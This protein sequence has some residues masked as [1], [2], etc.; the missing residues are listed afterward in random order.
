M[1]ESLGKLK[2]I[3]AYLDINID[4]NRFASRKQIQKIVYLIQEFGIDLNF[5]FSWYLHGPYCKELTAA[6]Y[7]EELD[8]SKVTS[9]SMSEKERLKEM[10]KFLNSDIKSSQKLELIA[11]LHY[12][13]DIG[14]KQNASDDEIIGL[15]R[16]RKPF[17][18]IDLINYYYK[19]VKEKFFKT[20]SNGVK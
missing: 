15:L 9:L 16:E 13:M 2:S 17:F 4:I 5:K 3:I 18:D 20:T 14:L 8:K 11:S 19:S 6:L 1:N 10:K 12:L 7:N